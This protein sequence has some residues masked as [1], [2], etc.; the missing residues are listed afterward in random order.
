MPT[1]KVLIVDDAV[2]QRFIIKAIISNYDDIETVGEAADGNEAIKQFILLK[3]D[4][5]ILDLV[6]PVLD[7]KAA[8]KKIMEIDD[9]AKIVVASSLGGR[10]D[11]EE[12]LR[13]GAIAF[14]QKPYDE[15]DLIRVIKQAN[16]E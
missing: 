13:A 10:E 5:L 12:C 3:P 4:V 6:M 1:I 7:G 11:I 9:K 8:L 14:V 16:T 15:D 2:S